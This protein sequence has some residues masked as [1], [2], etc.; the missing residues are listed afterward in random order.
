VPL[1]LHAG[2][3]RTAKPD[4]ADAYDEVRLDIDPEVQPDIVAS[5]TDLGDIGPF[6]AA[7]LSHCL[8][9]FY[10][11]EVPQVLAE[12]KRVLKPGGFLVVVVPDLQGIEPTEDVV[13]VSPGGPVCGLDM[14][15]GGGRLIQMSR[16]M[17][18]HCGFVRATLQE[19]MERAG[20][21]RCSVERIGGFN[22]L[23]AAVR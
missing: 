10:P 3:G 15:Y 7:Y 6:D 13:Y 1:L 17:A 19:V 14:I 11:H 8:E 21:D 20:F 18:H 22:L 9:H 12:L 2:C 23:A 16:Y 5:L 4:W